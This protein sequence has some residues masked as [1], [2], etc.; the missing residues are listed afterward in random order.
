MRWGAARVR[1]LRRRGLSQQALADELGVRQATVSDWERDVSPPAAPLDAC[2]CCWPSGLGSATRRVG[3]TMPVS[4][5]PAAERAAPS[6]DEAFVAWLW[7]SRAFADPWLVLS[8]GSRLRVVFAGRRWPGPGPDFRGAVLERP[9]STLLRGDV[10]VHLSAADWA[11]HG[12]HR[13]PRYAGVVLHV[14]LRQ[15][16]SPARR[17]DGQVVP[18]L[19]LGRQLSDSL[20]ALRA[21]FTRVGGAVPPGPACVQHVH[22]VVALLDAAGEARFLA[23]AAA[24]EGDLAAC[25][26]EQVFY[27]ALLVAMGY[28]ANKEPCARLAELLPYED[29]AAALLARPPARR[30]DAAQA[31]LL[32]RAGLLPATEAPVPGGLLREWAALDDGAPGLP[33]RAWALG[34]VRPDNAPPR[35][36]AGLGL[37]LAARAGT[38]WVGAL[39]A[40]VREAVVCPTPAPLAEL[41]RVQATDDFWPWQVDFGRPLEQARPWLIG[42]GRAMEVVV[43]VLLPG[44]YALGQV[45]GDEPLS[46]AALGCYRRFPATPGNRISRYM[47]QQVAGGV[48]RGLRLT[49]ARQQGLLHLFHEW[50]AGRWCERC[51]AGGGARL[52]ALPCPEGSEAPAATHGRSTSGVIHSGPESAAEHSD[53][54]G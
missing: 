30:A 36:L 10:E 35:R 38:D 54:P 45:H 12:H 11:A 27:R 25:S 33:R 50:C 2:C 15:A 46:A 28:S 43:N 39:A 17:I 34:S 4:P 47:A 49:A 53:D 7:E 18:T 19:V 9:D 29:L 32:G 44:C 24:L 22:D 16:G 3:A 31:L 21:R 40:A 6:A 52:A 5:S 42:R 14:V 51:P 23:R 26:A 41:F 48:P 1:A 8:D 37:W 20:P 13:D